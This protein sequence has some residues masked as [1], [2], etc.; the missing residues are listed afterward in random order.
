MIYV[1]I[2]SICFLAA[3]ATSTNSLSVDGF[4]HEVDNFK[5]ELGSGPFENLN[6]LLRSGKSSNDKNSKKDKK[7]KNDKKDE[8]DKKSKKSKKGE[9]HD[10]EIIEIGNEVVLGIFD[11][12]PLVSRRE[13]PTDDKKSK[14]VS[15]SK[16]DKKS[17]K[18][19][20]IS[21]LENEGPLSLKTL[22]T[23]PKVLPEFFEILPLVSR[24]EQTDD[25]KSKKDSKKSKKDK[26]SG[27]DNVSELETEGPFSLTLPILPIR[28]PTFDRDS[29]KDTNSRQDTKRSKRNGESM[30]IENSNDKKS[31]K[32]RKIGLVTANR[33]IRG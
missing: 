23:L 14:K 9:E 24:R 13:H 19:N 25:K 15:K 26:K 33:H 16:K 30:D 10:R 21:E 31:K 18:R 2:L 6:I 5:G 7:D 32:D 28:K 17:G 27:R 3:T 22:P 1:N 20:N 11:I 12:L 4:D 29:K 8:K